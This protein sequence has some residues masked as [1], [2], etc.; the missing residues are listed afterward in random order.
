MRSRGNS[1]ALRDSQRRV[2]P[3]LSRMLGYSPD[4]Y[5][6]ENLRLVVGEDAVGRERRRIQSHLINQPIEWSISLGLV[7]NTDAALNKIASSR[8]F[9]RDGVWRKKR[10]LLA[11]LLAIEINVNYSCWAS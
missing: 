6:P 1:V 11:F 5:W 7:A 9:G 3:L 4:G 10:S 2:A 8:R